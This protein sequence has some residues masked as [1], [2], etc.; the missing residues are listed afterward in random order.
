MRWSGYIRWGFIMKIYLNFEFE[1]PERWQNA[2]KWLKND[3]IDWDWIADKVECGLDHIQE[4]EGLP[5]DITPEQHEKII[6]ANKAWRKTHPVKALPAELQGE[7]VT[8]TWE[9]LASDDVL[10]T[11]KQA[12][13]E[14][15]AHA[16]QQFHKNM[17]Q[18]AI[19]EE[20]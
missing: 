1:V 10:H 17:I 7:Q 11:V 20:K 13:E 3:T 19:E 18:Q 9:A 15:M 8:I 12:I 14:S 4:Y 5:F 16:V 2:A 6:A